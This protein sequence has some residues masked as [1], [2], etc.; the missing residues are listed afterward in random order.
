MIY[1]QQFEAEFIALNFFIGESITIDRFNDDFVDSKNQLKL[2][3]TDDSIKTGK[4]EIIYTDGKRFDGKA[5]DLVGR[6]LIVI[7]SIVTQSIP[8]Q[9]MPDKIIITY[10]K[11]G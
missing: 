9:T 4:I 5:T 10:E 11:P 3:I 1:P 2:D 7:Y 6:K 8:L